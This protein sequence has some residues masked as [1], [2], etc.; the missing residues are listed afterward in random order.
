MGYCP[1]PSLDFSVVSEN[2]VGRGGRVGWGL[3]ADDE[4]DDHKQHAQQKGEQDEPTNN[5]AND[6]SDL[7]IAQSSTAGGHRSCHHNP[8]DESR[9]SGLVMCF[10]LPPSDV[11]LGPDR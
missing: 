3:G 7:A 8:E 1:W 9:V 5:T 2:G 10:L 11:K 6:A 4:E